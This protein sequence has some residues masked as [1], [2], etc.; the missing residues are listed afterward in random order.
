VRALDPALDH[1]TLAG[2]ATGGCNACS[3]A[4]PAQHA[5]CAAHARTGALWGAS[6]EKTA[7]AFWRDSA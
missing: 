4:A 6:E 5:V 1:A 3:A 7:Q 2:P